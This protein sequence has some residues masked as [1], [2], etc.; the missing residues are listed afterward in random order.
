[1]KDGEALKKRL[2]V[3]LPSPDYVSLSVASAGAGSPTICSL[4]RGTSSRK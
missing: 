4:R 2:E 3:L 1:M